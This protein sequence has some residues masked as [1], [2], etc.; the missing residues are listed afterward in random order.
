MFLLLC[1]SISRDRI[2]LIKNKNSWGVVKICSMGII[3]S[4]N[5]VLVKLIVYVILRM[6]IHVSVSLRVFTC[7]SLGECDFQVWKHKVFM[8][9]HS[10]ASLGMLCLTGK[11]H[12]TLIWRPNNALHFFKYP[13]EDYFHVL[14]A[15][16]EIYWDKITDPKFTCPI[17]PQLFGSTISLLCHTVV[18]VCG[19]CTWSGFPQGLVHA[20]SPCHW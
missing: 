14:L 2:L 1:L 19:G 12:I 7:W 20:L 11:H 8:Y 13:W 17:W 3:L 6:H 9:L 5:N 16:N 4:L 18:D 10:G 15:L